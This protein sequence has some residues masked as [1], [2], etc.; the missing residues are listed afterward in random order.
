[1]TYA[2][3]HTEWNKLVRDNIP[4][5]L[6]FKWIKVSSRIVENKQEL[7]MLLGHKLMEEMK[8]LEDAI[9]QA[10][11]EKILEEVADVQ[12]VNQ[13]LFSLIKEYNEDDID[14]YDKI[15]TLMSK[16]ERKINSTV[17]QQNQ[18]LI[19]KLQNIKNK[20]Y[21]EKWWFEKWVFLISTDW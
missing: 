17:I 13:K 9:A 4:A 14:W 1:M 16:A 10:D 3:W 5:T 8:E 20:K 11:Q 6:E 19:E 15:I 12:E 2:S 7:I 21:E 18:E